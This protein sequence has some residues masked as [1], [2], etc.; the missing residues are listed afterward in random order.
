[1]ELKD[2]LRE[3]LANPR[4]LRRLHDPGRD[5]DI[6]GG[7]AIDHSGSVLVGDTEAVADGIDPGHSDSLRYR[8]L[9]LVGI[10]LEIADEVVAV[11]EPV[12]LVTFVRVAG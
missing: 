1:M 8:K 5:D 6:R 9:K 2:R 7:D 4:D 10:L 3:P 11:V 12:G